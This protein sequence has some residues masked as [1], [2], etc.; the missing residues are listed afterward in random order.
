MRHASLA[1]FAVIALAACDSA[2]PPKPAA[3]EPVKPMLQS[4]VPA[5]TP[6]SAPEPSAD[7]RLLER[8]KNALRD[9]RKVDAQGVGVTVADGVVSLFGTAPSDAE[10]R[11]I[12]KFVAGIDG[13]KSVVS[14]LVIVRGS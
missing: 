3:A 2:E 11:G 10:R 1:A 6:P 12:Q 4:A 5:P 14:K 13:V 8:V 7:E 9:T